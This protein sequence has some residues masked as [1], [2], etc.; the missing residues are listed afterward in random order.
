MTPPSSEK[1]VP[2]LTTC[3]GETKGMG[4]SVGS[5]SRN[6]VSIEKVKILLDKVMGRIH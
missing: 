5:M 2:I 4:T 3:I 6:K 1:N